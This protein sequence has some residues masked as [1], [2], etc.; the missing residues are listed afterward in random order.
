MYLLSFCV[1]DDFFSIF[2]NNSGFGVLLVHPENTL[3]NGLDTSG[4]RAYRQF[5]HTSRLF[6]SLQFRWF[7]RISKKMGFVYSW[8]TLLWYQCYYR[9]WSRDALSLVFKICFIVWVKSVTIKQ[10]KKLYKKTPKIQKKIVKN[11]QKIQKSLKKN[12]NNFNKNHFF[13]KNMKIRKYLFF[14]NKKILFS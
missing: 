2:S 11:G 7:F 13:S 3:P 1:F 4:R 12:S 6:E 14:C 10:K 8:S 9:H 5:W